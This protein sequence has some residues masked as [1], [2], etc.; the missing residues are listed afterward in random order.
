MT[1]ET[2]EKMT[3]PFRKQGMAKGI[4]IAN[5]ICTLSMYVAYPLLLIYMLWKSDND[6]LRA[7]L[8]PATNF[9]ILTVF[10]KCI[11]RPRPYETFEMPP[12]IKK[13]TK[14]K[15]FPSRH[16]FSAM[17]IAM[18]FLLVSPWTVIGVVFVVLAVLLGI[19]RVL[20]GVHYPGDVIAG[21]LFAIVLA[22]VGYIIL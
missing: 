17:M 3:Q 14:G 6:L 5:K 11:N 9:L 15:S 4:H 7:V 18:T 13:E 1:K 10:R 16:V 12:V 21:A 20:S 22:I 19:V 2:Y 8:V